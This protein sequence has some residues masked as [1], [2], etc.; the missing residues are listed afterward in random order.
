MLSNPTNREKNTRKIYRSCKILSRQ[1]PKTSSRRRKL[2]F[3][4]QV[5]LSARLGFAL[6]AMWLVNSQKVYECHLAGQKH[7]AMVEKLKKAAV[8]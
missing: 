6:S 7:L 3:S 2:G 8:S 4:K 5:L 1:S